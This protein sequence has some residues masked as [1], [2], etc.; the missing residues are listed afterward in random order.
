MKVRAEWF[1]GIVSLERPRALV[2]VNRA[3][4]RLL[5]IAASSRWSGPSRDALSAPTEVHLVISRQCSA[6]CKSCYVDATPN[7]PAMSLEQAKAAL[8]RLA[9]HGVFHVALGGG[10]ALELDYLFEVAEHARRVGILPNLTTAGL[11]LT[12]AIAERC[13]VFGQINVSVDGVGADYEQARGFN[14]FARAERALRLLRAVKKEVGINCVVSRRSYPNLG[15]VVALARKLRLNEVE[16]LRFKPSGRGLATWADED[17][18]PEQARGIFPKA[19]WLTLRHLMRIKL[20][21]SFAPMVFWHRP[22]LAVARFFGVVGCE[23]G[24]LLASVMP[25]G[26]LTGCSFGGPNE[27]SIFDADATRR[28]FD[29]GFSAFRGYLARAPEPCRSCEYLSLCKGGCRVVAKA[30][31][32][33][34]QP[35]PGCPRVRAHRAEAGA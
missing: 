3:M 13:K 27:G 4:M 25:D 9:A 14:G 8:D 17:L 34:W 15:R 18:T 1:G 21:C 22:S 20:D 32:D 19:Q 31:G 30:A 6:G 7:G 23:G 33:W 10:E 28:A 11:G 26:A 24:N 29:G 12:P 2:S 16:L 35:D 5:G